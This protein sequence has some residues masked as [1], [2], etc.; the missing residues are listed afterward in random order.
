MLLHSTHLSMTHA[1]DVKDPSQN[2]M[3]RI[4]TNLKSTK[5]YQYIL[6]MHIVSH[7]LNNLK[8]ISTTNIFLNIHIYNY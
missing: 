1:E 8:D 5:A 6:Q 2:V 7:L 4:L 3:C